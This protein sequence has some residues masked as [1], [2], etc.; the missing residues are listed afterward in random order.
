MLK[1]RNITVDTFIEE[2]RT[3]IGTSFHH[4]G[5][6]KKTENHKGGV[7]CLGLVMGTLR[8]LCMQSLYRDSDGK[9]IP[10][11]DFDEVNY[12]HSPNGNHLVFKVEEHLLQTSAKDLKHGDM[13]LLKVLGTPQHIGIIVDTPDGLFILHSIM[14]ARKVNEVPLTNEWLTNA[15]C[16]YR[17]RPEHFIIEEYE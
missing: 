5:R 9:R 3:W 1:Y 7:D 17:F 11:I 4:Q 10:F 6:L 12:S 13:I 8:D 14:S 15:H 2:A 16:M